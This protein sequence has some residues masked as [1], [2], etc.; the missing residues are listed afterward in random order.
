MMSAVIGQ[1]WR[2][3]TKRELFIQYQA[4]QLDNWHHTA[5]LKQ[6]QLTKQAPYS[7]LHP[8]FSQGKT[9]TVPAM[10]GGSLLESY[11]G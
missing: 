10:A 6:I 9:D 11:T 5:H 4:A 3:K 7:I 2:P 1:D 8:F